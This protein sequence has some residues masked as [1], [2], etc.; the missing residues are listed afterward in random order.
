MIIVTIVA[1]IGGR[2]Y[3][4]SNFASDIPAKCTKLCISVF[5]SVYLICRG[6][7]RNARIR[8]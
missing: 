7:M 1:F 5:L 3:G 2:S 8:D 6:I 4:S